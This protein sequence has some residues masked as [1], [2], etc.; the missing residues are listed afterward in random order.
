MGAIDQL[1]SGGGPLVI[2][3]SAEDKTGAC[4]VLRE[5][6]RLA[7][8]ASARIAERTVASQFPLRVGARYVEILTRLG[9]GHVEPIDARDRAEA[10]RPHALQLIE[11]AS[12]VYFTGGDQARAETDVAHALQI[13]H[14][15]YYAHI[16]VLT[17]LASVLRAQGSGTII[18]FS[19][20][21]GVRVRRANYVYGSTKAGLDGFASG[22]A[23]ALHGT[24]ARLLL[25]R[26]GFVIGVAVHDDRRFVEEW[27]AR[28]WPIVWV[29]FLPIFF[30]YTGLRTD[31]GA[32]QGWTG[33]VTLLLILA[34]AFISKLGGGYAAARL[35][36]EGQRSALTIGVC[37]NTRGMMELIAINIGKDLGLLPTDVFSMLVIMA[38]AS[39]FIATPLIRRLMK[40]QESRATVPGE[41]AAARG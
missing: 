27:K 12:A 33:L 28:V 15:D 30:A 39:T 23:D 37:M 10:D 34:V 7:G 2:V 29:F 24:G 11:A 18:V 40:G 16:S 1:E 36:G 22:L 20:V 32:I 25:A 5:L 31:I 14:T 35:V 4:V 21:A 9:A 19:S 6:I 8:G 26:P 41:P 17:P 38:L 13:A 3:G